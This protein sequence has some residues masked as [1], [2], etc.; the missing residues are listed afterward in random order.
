[1]LAI[2]LCIAIVV[3]AAAFT[4]MQDAKAGVNR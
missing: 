1:M 3:G 4:W 2:I